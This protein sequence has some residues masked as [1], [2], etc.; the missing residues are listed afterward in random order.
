MQ[1]LGRRAVKVRAVTLVFWIL[2][3]LATTLGETGGDTVSMTWLGETTAEAGQAGINGYL[4]GSGMFSLLPVLLVWLKIRATHLR[5]VEIGQ[6]SR[7]GEED[8]R[9][10]LGS[11]NR[12]VSPAICLVCCGVHGLQL[13]FIVTVQTIIEVDVRKV[14]LI[15]AESSRQ[16]MHARHPAHC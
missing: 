9:W 6:L 8:R 1:A 2:K 16:R 13:G 4:V 11:C 3:T 7:G 14:L 10:C 15:V 5:Q 12:V